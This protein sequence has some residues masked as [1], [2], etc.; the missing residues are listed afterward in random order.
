MS[1][2]LLERTGWA[3]AGINLA[4][5]ESV[6][7]HSWSTSYLSF[8]LASSLKFRGESID[9]EKVLNMA[10]FHDISESRISD[11]PHSAIILGGHEM[12]HGKET[13]ESNAIQEILDPSSHI[14][15]KVAA[16]LAEYKEGLSLESRIVQGADL[17]DML[18]YAISLEANGV[19][20]KLLKQFFATSRER[21]TSLNVQLVSKIYSHLESEH[22]RYLNSE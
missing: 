7:E 6:A 10:I 13:A 3:I 12:R 14:Y 19:D 18:F 1:L 8:L 9:I 20:P 2:K 4:R 11:I 21:I 17:L 16:I 22:K 5:N 15:E